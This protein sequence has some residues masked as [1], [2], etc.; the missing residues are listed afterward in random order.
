MC[1]ET[2]QADQQPNY[3]AGIW[4]WCPS[5]REL[6]AVPEVR[7]AAHVERVITSQESILDSRYTCIVKLLWYISQNSREWTGSK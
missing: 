3:A 5:K 1:L 7:L 4:I 2:P 6:F